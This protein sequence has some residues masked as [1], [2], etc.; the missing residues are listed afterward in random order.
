MPVLVLAREEQGIILQI[1]PAA[2]VDYMDQEA[3]ED[4][5]HTMERHQ[6]P[7]EP[8]AVVYV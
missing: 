5:E 1:L 8:E 7:E 2:M 4:P 3:E 6:E